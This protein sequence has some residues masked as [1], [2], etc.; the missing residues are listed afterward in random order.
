MGL[1]GRGEVEKEGASGEGMVDGVAEVRWREVGDD[2]QRRYLTLCFYFKGE[3]AGC[4]I[5][6]GKQWA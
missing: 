2:G 1:T 5:G 4:V 3:W 6:P